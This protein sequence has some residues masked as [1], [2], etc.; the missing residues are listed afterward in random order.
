MFTF[1][2]VRFAFGNFSASIA[3]RPSNV[4]LAKTGLIAPATT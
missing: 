2:P 1:R 4:I 3:S